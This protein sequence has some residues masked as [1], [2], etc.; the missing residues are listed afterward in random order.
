MTEPRD[1]RPTVFLP[2]TDF[3][4]KAGLPQK[5]PVILSRWQD[6]GI[7]RKVREARKG[8][9]KFILHD[10]P[11]YAN[12]DMHIG[13]ALNHILKDM[14]CR[15]QTLLGKDAPYVP[16]WDCHGLPIEWKVEEEYRKKK[17]NKDEVPP[18]EFRAECRAYAQKWVDVQ[19]EQLK[20]LG[21]NGDWDNPYLTMDSQA[22]G[23]IVRELLKFAESG[24]LYRG[25]K[26]V[27]WSPVEKTALAEAEVEY[28][29]IVS[30]QI[31]V[32]FSVLEAPNAPDGVW[33]SEVVIWTT[34]PWTIPTNQAVAYNPAVDYAVYLVGNGEQMASVLVA[35]ALFEEFERRTG[36]KNEDP[37]GEPRWRLKPEHFVGMTLRHPMHS[38]G[39]FFAKPRPMLPGDFVTTDSGTGLVHMAPD[40]GEDDFALCKAHGIEPVFAVQGDGKY[41][42]DWGWLGGQ[43]SVINP[44]FNAPDGPICSDLREAGGLL[45]AS[46]DYKHSYPHSWRSKAKVIYRCTPQWFV[47]MDRE[48]EGGTLREKATKA[49]ADTR[50][51]PE[52][53]RNRIGAM[54]EGRPDWVLSRQRAWGVPI[55]LFVDRKTGQYLNDPDVNARIVAAVMAEGVDAWDEERAQEYL[56]DKYKLDDYERVTDILDVW[57]DSG[58]TH[59]FVLESGRWP[60]LQWPANLY[61]EGS[62][63][64]RGWFQSSLLESCA[65]RGRAPYD[66]VLTHGFTMDQKGMKMSKSL[67][68]TISPIDLMRD[69]GADIL[70]LWALSVDF[71]EDHRIGKEILQG[72]A[73]QYRKLRNTYRYLLGALEGFSEDERLPVAE[74]PE[75]EQYMLGLLGKLD[76]TLRQAVEDFDYNTYVRA[77]TDFCNEDLSALFFDIRKDCLY[78]DAPSD[79]KR[80]AYR[81]VLDTLFHALVRY[82]APVL[83][84]T[85]EEVW[86]SRYPGSDSV[87]L[88]EWPEVPAVT[89]DEARWTELRALRQTVNEAIEPLRREKVLGSGLEAVVTVPESAPEA[90][91]AELFITATVMRGQGSDVTVTRST[92]HKCGRCWRLLPEVTEDGALCDRCDEVVAAIDAGAA[93]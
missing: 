23:T 24:Q 53:G 28:E 71:T 18:R 79:P 45:A 48:A 21:I 61:L 22:E 82:G 59:A 52:K 36:W 6:E 62:D 51:V 69:Y 33:D 76:A 54:V 60:D 26:P 49:I 70:R 34:T 47:P 57:F 41:R 32:A 25:A 13:H 65:T 7:Y 80:R 12:G 42:E 72:V 20:R 50:F 93:A 84:F 39:G 74:M 38:L 58:S 89:V 11:P 19:R 81:T 90:D 83:V 44:K 88:L 46:A 77:L 8:R 55:T 27:M 14:V 78:C 37:A 66:A 16:G 56:G 2:K 68:N 10:G 4:M 29:D 87:H 40:H 9:E 17:K 1:F 31:D 63:Q 91:L 73:D 30:T 5:E 64:H 92:D 3:P 67:G 85:A 35:E 75:L 86:Q 43:G 15:T